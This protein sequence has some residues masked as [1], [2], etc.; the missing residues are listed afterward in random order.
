VF[1]RGVSISKAVAAAAAAAAGGQQQQQQPDSKGSS[2]LSTAAAVAAAAAALMSPEPQP[3]LGNI[4][5]EQFRMLEDSLRRCVV[6]GGGFGELCSTT[7][8]Y[9]CCRTAC[10]FVKVFRDKHCDGHC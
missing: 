4:T 1:L 7:Q 8:T 5:L 3:E 6:W 2:N 10:T 9:G